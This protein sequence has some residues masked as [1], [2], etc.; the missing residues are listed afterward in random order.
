MYIL[1]SVGEYC[2]RYV[3]FF[4]IFLDLFSDFSDFSLIF[5]VNFWS[6]YINWQDSS[7]S[8]LYDRDIIFTGGRCFNCATY[9]K[10][11]RYSYVI[12]R[13]SDKLDI[14]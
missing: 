6:N 8:N 11:T 13:Q 3:P 12:Q 10:H 1:F 4:L 2:P 9:S 7:I 14:K 5:K